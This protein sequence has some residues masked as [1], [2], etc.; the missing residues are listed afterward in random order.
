MRCQSTI[1]KGD[2]PVIDP[3]HPLYTSAGIYVVLMT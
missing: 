2:E 1:E 3:L